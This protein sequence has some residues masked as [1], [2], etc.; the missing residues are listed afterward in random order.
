M[1]IIQLDRDL[2][3][4]FQSI[5]K[6]KFY[7][8]ENKAEELL[9]G[10]FKAIK[11]ITNQDESPYIELSIDELRMLL[12]AD[13]QNFG[14]VILIEQFL[15]K[16]LS[17]SY[18]GRGDLD[19]WNLQPDIRLTTAKSPKAQTMRMESTG[20]ETQTVNRLTAAWAKLYTPNFRLLPPSEQ[21]LSYSKLME[22]ASPTG[23]AE[24]A[25]KLDER[26]LRSRCEVASI[27]TSSLYSSTLNLQEVKRLAKASFEVYRILIELYRQDV[28]NVALPLPEV[29]TNPKSKGA[30]ARP[31]W[32]IPN[33][34]ALAIALEPCLLEVRQAYAQSSDWRALGFLTTQLKFCNGWLMD[35]FT[36]I[37]LV[38][39]QPYLLCVEEQVAHPWQRVCAAAS[40]HNLDSPIIH[41]TEK[42][43]PLSQQI[44]ES[45]FDTLVKQLPGHYSRSGFLDHPS[46]THS[47]V[48]DL[49]MF[50]AYLWLCVLEGNLAAIEQELL[51]LCIRALPSLGVKWELIDLWLIVLAN[52]LLSYLDLEQQQYVQPYTLEIHQIFVA[53]RGYFDTSLAR[54]IRTK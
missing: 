6:D 14:F 33:I 16:L 19:I 13:S 8:P 54:S 41:L 7:S 23:R 24:T 29:L 22:A 28:L 10:K 2:L 31:V 48:R 32:G 25:A 43:I 9:L 5:F 12:K 1:I 40:R 39:L 4:E 35:S 26:L 37:E 53:A 11:K 46:I 3:I 52:E 42:M 36:P 15:E 38:L 49:K 17:F 44:A 21:P 18:V 20:L 30:S 27:Q 47:C 45:A 51:Q 50:Q 34:K